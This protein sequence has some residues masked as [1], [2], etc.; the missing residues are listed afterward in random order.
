VS[1]RWRIYR[2]IGS[3]RHDALVV[4]VVASRG[5]AASR[6][7]EPSA[8]PKVPSLTAGVHQLLLER[9]APASVVVSRRYEILFFS[10]P[11]DRYLTQ[12]PGPPTQDLLARVREGC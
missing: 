8:P 3:T 1:K 5:V 6:K 12:P 2:R 4:P 10:G 11:V 7:T 9:Y